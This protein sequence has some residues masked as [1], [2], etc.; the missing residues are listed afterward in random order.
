MKKTF[1][2]SCFC[3]L[4]L[5]SQAQTA[6]ALVGG[7]HGSTISPEF[8]SRPDSSKRKTATAGSH[9]AFGFVATVPISKVLAFQSGV[10]Y[11]AK[12]DEHTQFY[13]TANLYASTANLPASKKQKLLSTNTVLNLNYIEMPFLLLLKLPIKGSTKF[14]LGGGPQLSLFYNGSTQANNLY[15]LQAHPDSAVRYSFKGTENNDLP[16]GKAS[17]RYRILHFGAKA[18]GGMEFGRVFLTVNY[19]Q[20]LQEFFEENGRFYKAQTIGANLGIYLGKRTKNSP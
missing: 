15:V 19:T 10:L 20:D 18:F 12:G 8:L 1:V 6:I 9:L 4:A 2:L 7:V 14:I 17:G 13:D 11:T 5:F 3:V 16:V